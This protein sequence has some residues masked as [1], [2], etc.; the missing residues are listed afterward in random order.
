MPDLTEAATRNAETMDD[1]SRWR[2]EVV[3]PV[4]WAALLAAVGSTIVGA[5][6]AQLITVT[7]WVTLSSAVPLT[8]ALW[9]TRQGRVRSGALLLVL[10]IYALIT[11]TAVWTTPVLDVVYLYAIAI[12]MAGLALGRQ[13]IAA[14][15]VVGGV[16]VVGLLLA[17]QRGLLPVPDY[18]GG[19]TTTVIAALTGLL[20]AAWA[21]SRAV[22]ATERARAGWLA[23][24]E[25]LQTVLAELEVRV[26]QRTAALSKANAKLHDEV[27]IR[28]LI[29]ADLLDAR[30]EAEAATEA[31]A[32][33]VANV[34]HE[35]RTPLNGI[36]G[37][38]DL[39][40]QADLPEPARRHVE[41]IRNCGTTMVGL[42]NDVLDFSRLE[43]EGV[44][45]QQLDFGLT[46]ALEGALAP[47]QVV[48]ARRQ[49]ALGL[50]VDDAIPRW[51]RGDPNRLSQIVANL[52]GNAVKF[53]PEG[54]VSVE[55]DL[56]HL[57]PD[58]V[59]VRVRVRDT[60][61]GMSEDA[62]Q[63]VFEPFVQ[64]DSSTTR[65]YGGTGLGLTI[66]KQLVE[67]MGGELTLESTL[68]LGTSFE[69]TL[70]FAAPIAP[71]PGELASPWWTVERVSAPLEVLI[72]EDNPVNLEV[73]DAMLARL[74]HTRVPATT[75]SDA[76]E[77]LF[78]RR[79]DVVLMDCQLPGMDGLELTRAVRGRPGPNRET[80]FI[81]VTAHDSERQREL[82]IA[83]GMHEFVAKPVRFEVLAAALRAVA[84][85]RHSR[86]DPQ[87]LAELREL[88]G[89]KP[90]LLASMSRQFLEQSERQVQLI[91]QAGGE[92]LAAVAEA[93][94]A[95]KGSSAAMGARALAGVA[96]LIEAD[97]R[98]GRAS[99][100]RVAELRA[101]FEA[102]R[103]ELSA[104]TNLGSSSD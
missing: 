68:G 48:A 101:T 57:D 90:G 98:S 36:L 46:N 21:V 81:A 13:A 39:L 70:K 79:F 43:A 91:E 15:A 9:L 82:T 45:L 103:P 87:T 65:E 76:L 30:N 7:T 86:L 23:T 92:A 19:V 16:L 64:A 100:L 75:G 89:V 4:C 42:V 34:S 93:A 85:G 67:Q 29:H 47:L 33:F 84:P 8:V 88:E 12:F 78:A 61:V 104:L 80:P 32:R 3:E 72:V 99:G 102:V 31:K 56:D 74:G 41:T 44:E 50:K 17:E 40:A 55:A 5:V 51:L 38:G 49:L 6:L 97:A 59:W 77:L 27:Q 11:V 28:N 63:R 25:K 26:E 96:A 22:A 2:S 14:L 66:A 24:T 58:G 69:F 52:A 95:L 71:L 60:G 94:H 10:S 83:A 53:T 73:S 37:I 54:S 35:I 20:M 18:P 62:A 1:G